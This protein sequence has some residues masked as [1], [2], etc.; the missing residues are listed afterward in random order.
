MVTALSLTEI[1]RSFFSTPGTSA[2]TTISSSR[3]MTSTFGV[4]IS[5]SEI[6]GNDGH[7]KR[8]GRIQPRRRKRSNKWSISSNGLGGRAG[9]SFW[10]S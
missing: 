8:H 5:G 2:L 7:S 1:S 9:D 4:F 10:T 3:S 6:S